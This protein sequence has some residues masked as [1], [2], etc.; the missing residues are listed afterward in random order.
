MYASDVKWQM[1]NNEPI[2][3]TS[4]GNFGLTSLNPFVEDKFFKLYLDSTVFSWSY[5]ILY[6]SIATSLVNSLLYCFTPLPKKQPNYKKR[7]LPS[8]LEPE[9]EKDTQSYYNRPETRKNVKF[10]NDE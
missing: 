8:R 4:K 5:W 10:M 3:S 7:P 6:G 2:S 9:L 1:E